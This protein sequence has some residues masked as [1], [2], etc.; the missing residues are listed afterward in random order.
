MSDNDERRFGSDRRRQP[1]GGRRADDHAGYAPLVLV[2]DPDATGRAAC[3]AI[4]AKLRFAVAPME[5]VDKAA[6]IVKALRPE[7]IVAETGAADELRRRL[8][9][10]G[11]D[12]GS[13]PV[14]GVSSTMSP[15][16]IVDRIRH[17]LREHPVRR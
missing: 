14:I 16:E 11:H 8:A 17:A 2:V 7:V 10:G 5:T 1:R 13:I 4:L 3:E 12:D 6:S 9:I 15:D